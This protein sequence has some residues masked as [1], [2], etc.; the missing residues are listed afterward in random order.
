MTH[1]RLR[2]AFPIAAGFIL[3][4]AGLIAVVRMPQGV[5]AHGSVDQQQLNATEAITSSAEAILGQTFT[6]AANNLVAF[7]VSTTGCLFGLPRT[8]TFTIRQTPFTT[9]LITP[10]AH[11]MTDGINHIDLPGGAI[12]LTPGVK[13]VIIQLSSTMFGGGRCFRGISANLYAGGGLTVGD[14]PFEVGCGLSSEC[15]LYFVTYSQAGG[16]IAT[17]TP[18]KSG[19]TPTPVIATATPS[20]T[21]PPTVIKGAPTLPSA[22]APA[23]PT[24]AP[25]NTPGL[26]Q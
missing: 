22:P 23:T 16:V 9:D 25:T 15:D 26:K 3:L 5:Q 21:P 8:D 11:V 10:F 4:V 14:P 13:Y 24:I 19:N 17:N 1:C 12:A 2:D 20:M 6:P 7:D 18:L